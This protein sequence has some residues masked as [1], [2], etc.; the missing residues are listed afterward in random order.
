MT[1]QDRPDE[2]VHPLAM[3][4]LAGPG[5]GAEIPL[6]VNRSRLRHCLWHFNIAKFFAVLDCR[7]RVAVLALI[8]GTHVALCMWGATVHSPTVDEPA[9]LAAGLSHWQFGRFDLCKVSPPLVRLIAAIPVMLSEPKVDWEGYKYDEETESG[10]RTE[11]NVGRDFLLVNGERSFWLFTIGRWMCIPFSLVG[12]YVCYRWAGDLFGQASAYAALVLWCFSPNILAHAQL[13]TPDIG[14]TSLG[15]AACYSFWRWSTDSHWRGALAWG[16]F[17]GL[18]VLAKTNAVVLYAALPISYFVSVVVGRCRWNRQARLLI[19]LGMT[20]SIL[21]LNLGYGFEGSCRPLGEYRFFSST[22]AGSAGTN[23]FKN[24][25]WRFLPVPLPAAFLEG[26]DLQRRDFENADGSMK[27]YFRGE[28]YDHGW[29]WY[30]LY[31][32]AVKAPIGTLVLCSMALFN[33]K[34]DANGWSCL[35]SVGIPGLLLFVL[36]SSQTGIGHAFRYI[37]PAVPFAFVL[38]AGMFG[39][40]QARFRGLLSTI[41]LLTSIASSL[42]VYPHSLSYFNELAGGPN[43][44]Q[45]HLLDGNCDWGQDLLFIRQWIRANPDKQPVY[46]SYW[47]PMPA[48]MLGRGLVAP[49]IPSDAPVP[50]GTYLISVNLLHN[51]YWNGR[52]ELNALRKL[53]AQTPV[54]PAISRFEVGPPSLRD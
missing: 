3:G 23:R 44:G 40:P 47:G 13:L 18:A 27:T 24:T 48:E 30:Y 26:I 31:V 22:F 28:W 5:D 49:S 45:F 25:A 7:C 34:R 52:P 20:T 46:V 2:P 10:V 36:A 54:T 17:L 42:R 50:A 6:A 9:Y 15:L 39:N 29:W 1:I 19:P 51:Q 11:H 41:L 14:V 16:T 33:L 4:T 32:V 8:T 43:H 53:E 21:V 38:A 35:G 37:L 12:A